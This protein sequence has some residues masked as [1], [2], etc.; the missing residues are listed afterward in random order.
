AEPELAILINM[1]REPITFSL[2][3]GVSW[4]RLIDTQSYFDT[5]GL[6][7]EPTGYFNDNDDDLFLSANINLDNPLAVDEG[8]Y[9]VQGS[10]IVILRERN[11]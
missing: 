4:E 6:R 3:S 1:T 11:Q 2:P 10:S 9:A 7:N 8:S 5:A